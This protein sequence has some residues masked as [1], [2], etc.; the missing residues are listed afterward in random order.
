MRYLTKDGPGE[1]TYPVA[2]TTAPTNTPATGLPTIS[3]TAQV[4]ETLTADTSG[5]ADDDGLDNVMFSY[6]WQADGADISGATDSTYTLVDDDAGKA[7]SVAVSFTDDAGSAE[8]VTSAA[9]AAV[10]APPLTAS[11]ENAPSS[12]DGSS[13]FTFDLRFSEELR[14]GYR[15]LRDHAFT[16]D[17]GTVRNASRLE[18]GSNRGWRIEVRPN[19]NDDVTVVL[20]VT[21][22]CNDDGAICTEDGRK[23]SSRVELTVN[24][25]EQQAVNSP[26]TGAPTISGTAQV[27]GTLT[28]DTSGV[29][30]ADGLSNASFS[31]QWQA[32]GADI[33]SA[34]GSSYTL[35][36]SDEGKAVSVTVSFTDDTGSDETLTSAATTAVEAAPLTPLTASVENAAVSHDGE[37]V[38]T[39]E[40]RFSEEFGISYKTLRDH[41]FTVTGGT[42]R[43][44]QRLEQGSNIGWRITV[45][46]DSSG[47]VTI[48]LPITEDCDAQGAICTK[49][50]RKLSTELELTVS[51]P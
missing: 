26:A 40:L 38:F 13:N 5:I 44:A 1:W 37:S 36:D 27:G 18:P 30:D 19:V 8:S 28:A 22:D 50:G 7:V 11:F 15:T 32:G 47:A 43:K 25:P 9:T 24:G 45:S 49:D 29:A 3:G 16:V 6:Q 41:A 12:H 34:T 17:G 39:F 33:S 31:Y 35:V 42:V 21:T 46:P 20:P 4:G 14:V 23:L 48:I 2:A 10:A 51:G